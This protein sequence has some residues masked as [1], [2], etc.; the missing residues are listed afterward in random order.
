[1]YKYLLQEIIVCSISQPGQFYKGLNSKAMIIK[2]NMAFNST[3][4]KLPTHE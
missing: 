3:S 1:M 4:S 2:A